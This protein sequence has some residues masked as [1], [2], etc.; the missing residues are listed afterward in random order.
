M[1]DYGKVISSV[2]PPEQYIDDYSV[3]I[4]TEIKPIT[5]QILEDKPFNGYEYNLVQYDKNEYIDMLS[6][7]YKNLED[8][9]SDI[10]L[11]MCDLYEGR[12]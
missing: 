6:N 11:A 8:E 4:A 3:W 7:R 2:I 1:K 5:A 10:E 12:L 9:I